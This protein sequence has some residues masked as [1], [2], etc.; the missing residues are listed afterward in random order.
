MIVSASGPVM[1]TATSLPLTEPSAMTARTL[2][3]LARLAPADSSMVTPGWRA[4][5]WAICPAGRACRCLGSTTLR[6]TV[7]GAPA[8]IVAAAGGGSELAGI[9]GLLCGAGDGGQVEPSAGSDRG[10]HGTFH[11][12]RVNEQDLLAVELGV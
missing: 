7:S 3:A 2:R 1:L 9:A 5:T 8:G 12:W 4:A 6:C 11:E 10:R